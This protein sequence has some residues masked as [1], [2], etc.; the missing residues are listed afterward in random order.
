MADA[1]SVRSARSTREQPLPRVSPWLLRWFSRYS[2]GYLARHFHAVRGVI[3]SVQSLPADRPAVVCMNHPS[4]WDPLI[5]LLLAME[6]FP[7]RRHYAAMDAEALQGYQFFERLGF[8]GVERG[9]GRGAVR[10]LRLGEQ[11]LSVPESVL[12]ITPHGRYADVRERPPRLLRGLSTLLSRTETAVV[13]PLALEYGFWSERLP[14]AFAEFG[15][16]L[17][18]A[19]DGSRTPDE[20]AELLGERLALTQ[21]RLAQRVMA[22]DVRA[23]QTLLTGNSGMG[24]LYGWWRRW[25]GTTVP[26]VRAEGGPA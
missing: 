8:F 22:R 12:W 11:L 26:K 13:L 19:A 15:E 18:G 21:D 9:S 5:G 17:P 6:C 10:F 14:E 16:P 2:R 1:V 4:W 23:F 25:R 20:W 7:G 3:D 24:N